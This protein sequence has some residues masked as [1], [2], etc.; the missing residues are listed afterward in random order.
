MLGR[1]F[2]HPQI[3]VST[4]PPP[5]QKKNKNANHIKDVQQFNNQ[6]YLEI[7]DTKG[8]AVSYYSKK[9]QIIKLTFSIN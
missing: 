7:Y 2:N 9:I 6:V 5:P 1:F 4:T 3:L 8:L